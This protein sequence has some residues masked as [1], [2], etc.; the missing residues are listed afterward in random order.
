MAFTGGEPTAYVIPPAPQP[1]PVLG[2][3]PPGNKI[4]NWKLIAEGA[5]L[6]LPVIIRHGDIS[7]IANNINNSFVTRIE[8]LVTLDDPRPRQIAHS[9][10]RMGV[11]IGYTPLEI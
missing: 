10:V 4:F 7:R 11:H 3:H 8:T 6:H 1:W 9:A 2:F 5:F